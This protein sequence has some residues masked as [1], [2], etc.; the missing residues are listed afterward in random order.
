[1]SP[2]QRPGEVP[3][4]SRDIWALALVAF[5]TLTGAHPFT[6]SSDSA[7]PSH[8]RGDL[9]GPQNISPHGRSETV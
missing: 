7:A 4:E 8:D 2:E 3:A 5:E 1:M 6:A 9:D